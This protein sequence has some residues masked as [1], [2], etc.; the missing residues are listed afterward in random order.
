MKKVYLSLGGNVGDTLSI[1]LNVII[2]ITSYKKI[3]S[4]SCSS[5][6]KT[7]PVG[8]KDQA[9]FINAV[10]SF[11]SELSAFDLQAM[12]QAIEKK[13]KKNKLFCN[14][15]RTVDIDILFYGQE[16]YSTP[17]LTIP[18][19]RWKERLFVLYPLLDLTS[20]IE[21]VT[22]QFLDIQAI[23]DN[24][25]TNACNTRQNCTVNDQTIQ[26]SVNKKFNNFGISKINE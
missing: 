11:E 17:S 6:Y 24:I 15:P 23:I 7:A 20:Q 10:L 9:H 25:E 16:H 22:G 14:G 8:Y 2:D 12:L 3:F 26:L 5:F 19:P 4:P 18:H 1:L 21:V 13:Y